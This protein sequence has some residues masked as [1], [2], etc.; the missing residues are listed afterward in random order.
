MCFAVRFYVKK[1]NT[2]G[3]YENVTNEKFSAFN[4]A[5]ETG[6][7]KDA[8]GTLYCQDARSV[9]AAYPRRAFSESEWRMCARAGKS[10]AGSTRRQLS[11]AAR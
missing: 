9:E 8:S 1:V 10:D 6:V 3:T 7:A 11:R 4:L 2:A 5:C